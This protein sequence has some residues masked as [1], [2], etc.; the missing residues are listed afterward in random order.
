MA[1]KEYT[2]AERIER[3]I[4]ATHKIGP[5]LHAILVLCIQ[6]AQESADCTPL[7]RLV[8][9][10]HVSA[11]P[12]AMKAWAKKFTPITWNGDDQVKLIP[13]TNK[14]FKPFDIDGAM[15]SPYWNEIETVKKPLTLA[16]LMKIVEGMEK[17]IDKAEKEDLIAEGEDVQLMRAFVAKVT[18]AAGQPIIREVVPGETVV[19]DK[20]LK[21]A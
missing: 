17:R 10:V 7:H 13:S 5:E 18:A 3:A 4:K 11:A 9:G 6:H 8:C 21:A 14:L 20:G 16:A 12:A 15:A 2:L 19:A 1:K